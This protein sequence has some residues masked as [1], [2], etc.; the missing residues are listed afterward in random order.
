MSQFAVVQNATAATP[1]ALT[2]FSDA[3]NLRGFL[4]GVSN[5]LPGATAADLELIFGWPVVGQKIQT[6]AG[7]GTASWSFPAG[8]QPRISYRVTSRINLEAA[9]IFERTIDPIRMETVNMGLLMLPYV[10]MVSGDWTNT[11]RPI[12]S[13]SADPALVAAS[14]MI[15]IRNFWDGPGFYEWSVA[16]PADGSQTRYQFPAIPTAHVELIPPAGAGW[17]FSAT[18]N[19]VEGGSATFDQMRQ[20]PSKP[21][22][23]R[24]AWR[25]FQL[26]PPL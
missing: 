13:W 5:P 21:Y 23:G 26:G 4:L 22:P 25:A 12:L 2:G 18:V 1:V 20:E 15:L 7:S 8:V 11:A 9:S 10:G 16:L 19:Y 6:I 17:T 14:K 24:S 3:S